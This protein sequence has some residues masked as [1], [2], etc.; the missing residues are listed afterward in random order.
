ML[1]ITHTRMFMTYSWEQRKLM[2]ETVS[3]KVHLKLFFNMKKFI[4]KHIKFYL[5]STKTISCFSWHLTYANWLFAQSIITFGCFVVY[6]VTLK[7][8]SW[9]II[10]AIGSACFTFGK[11]KHSNNNNGWRCLNCHSMLFQAEKAIFCSS[12][13]DIVLN[14]AAVLETVSVHLFF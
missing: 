6:G 8:N 9:L 7:A 14:S 2:K 13:S 10:W 12:D 4:V 11:A 5:V 3:M 1:I